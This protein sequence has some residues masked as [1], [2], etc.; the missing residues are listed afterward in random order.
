MAWIAV[1][2]TAVATAGQIYTGMKA[3]D[4]QKDA[5][6]AQ[7]R[8]QRVQAW[9]DAMQNI[10]DIQLAD[11]VSGTAWQGSGASLE[12]SGAQGVSSAIGAQGAFNLSLLAENV[13]NANN[14]YNATATASKWGG[15]SQA[16]GSIADIS[17]MFIGMGA[18]PGS[19]PG[20]ATNVQSG[21]VP[22]AT[23]SNTNKGFTAPV[24]RPPSYGYNPGPG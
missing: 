13:K 5:N 11:A 15:Y 23:F 21:S 14:Y 2:V 1:G 8:Q 6:K 18:A 7:Q 9:V 22:G 4:A 17:K 3:A 10:K 19:T 20:T 24:Q 12:S 16:L